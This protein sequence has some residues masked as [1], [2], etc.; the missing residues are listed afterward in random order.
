MV[1][2]IPKVEPEV[3]LTPEQ[4]QRISRALSEPNRYAA[5]RHI[6]GDSDMTC[7]GISSALSISAGTTSHHIRELENADLIRVTKDGRYKHLT[8]RRDIWRAYVAQLT[9]L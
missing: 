4:F 1:M 6:Y 8:P 2:P 3:E 5:L 7:G 9:N